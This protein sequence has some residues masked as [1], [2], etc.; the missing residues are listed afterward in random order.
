MTGRWDPFGKALTPT[1]DLDDER[2]KFKVITA[3]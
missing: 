1:G 2:L 3:A